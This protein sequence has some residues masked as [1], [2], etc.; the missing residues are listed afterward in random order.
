[1]NK[2][3][4]KRKQPI[5]TSFFYGWIIVVIGAIGIFFS[6]PGQTYSV[7]IFINHYVDNLGW[8]R[9]MV[10]SYYSIATLIAGF[11]LPI[12]GQAID[13][14]GHRKLIS[15]ISVALGL[16]C[17]WMSFVKTPIMLAFGFIF[18]RLLGQGSMSLLPE[19]LIP[20]WFV[21]RRAQAISFMSLGKVFSS[22]LLPP[23]NSWLIVNLGVNFTWRFWTILLVF[24]MAPLAWFLVVDKPEDISSKTDGKI[25]LKRRMSDL[26]YQTETHASEASWTVKEAIKTKTFWV[27]LFCVM[28][29]PMIETGITF[30]MVSI[31]EEKGFSSIFAALL[32][33][34]IAIVQLPLTFLAGYVLDRVKVH[35]VKAVSFALYF[36]S[37]IMLLQSQS[38]FMLIIHAI[39][40][41]AFLAFDMVSTGV[42]WPNYFGIK[43][44]GSIR[45]ITMTAI[46]IGSSLGPLPFG[47]AYDFFGGYR[48]ILLIMMI[49]PAIASLS[50]LFSPIPKKPEK[51]EKVDKSE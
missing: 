46:V 19:T 6:G 40:K 17:L 3:I 34:I 12:V 36:L 11:A 9:A 5:K 48:E 31:I 26:K 10:S 27:M 42:L 29:T 44:L 30:H 4:S 28:I 2:S 23:L 50:C 20:L 14:K 43:H 49:F 25:A 39:I 47:F 24:F 37:I 13:K 16:A 15:S 32:L 21:D 18:L 7:S 33:S 45:S 8:S 51:L 1:M 38:K 35:H 41:G 22:A